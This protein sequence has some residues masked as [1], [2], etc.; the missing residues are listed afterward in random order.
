M[1][2][3]RHRLKC[4]AIVAVRNEQ[5]HIRRAVRDFARDGIDVVVIDN[6]STDGTRRIC[7][8][9]LGH[10]VLRL[11]RLP[12]GGAF[13][14]SAQLEAKQ[15]VIR[16]LHHDWIIHAD[17]DEVLQSNVEGE[18]LLEGIARADRSGCN[19]VN[20]EEFVF[21]PPAGEQP[22]T[23]RYTE[24]FLHYYFHEPRPGRLMRAWRRTDALS[25][26]GSGGHVLEGDVRLFPENFVLRHYM[27]L[28]EVHA[29]EKYGMRV[30]ASSDVAK[31][32]HRR[33]MSIDPSTLRLPP[34]GQLLRLPHAGSRSFDRSTPRASHF[35]EW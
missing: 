35:W 32:W 14:L 3:M 23:S 6:D 21:L 30:F 15:R 11:E 16:S 26:E 28:S 7:E 5:I 10:G 2:T 13:D 33:R 18:A 4:C 19:A 1:S 27:V 24:S 20:F 29:R 31:G 25:N 22:D 17:A 9:L 8:E 34:E 12:W